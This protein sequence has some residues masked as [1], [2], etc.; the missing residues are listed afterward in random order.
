MDYPNLLLA[1]RASGKPQY[2]IAQDAAMREGRLSEII[3]R[4]GAQAKERAVLSRILGVPEKVL[5]Q[6][7]GAALD[8]SLG[9]GVRV[10]AQQ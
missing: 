7:C 6:A 2:R 1:I 8:G 10:E 3:R 4:G 9:S 5:F